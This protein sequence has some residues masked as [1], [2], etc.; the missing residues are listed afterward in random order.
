MRRKPT[1]LQL[2]GAAALKIVRVC[3]TD[4]GRVFFTHHAEKRM[5]ERKITRPQVLA[6]LRKG[7]II[8]GPSSDIKG[9]WNCV[10]EYFS[11][12]ER[13]TVVVGVE[14]DDDGYIAIVTVY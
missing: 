7:K 5:R 9:R 3:A 10:M 12:G 13:I 2:S 4:S 1:S 14:R 11:C 8:E 6:C